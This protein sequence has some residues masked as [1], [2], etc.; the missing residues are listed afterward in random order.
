MPWYIWII[1]VIVAIFF[2]TYINDKQKRERLMKKY[3]DEVLVE[4]L[5]SGS[6]WQG[7]PKGQLIDALGKPEQIS[8]QVLK[9]RKK[10]IWKYQ[11]TG[12]NRYALKITIEDGKVIGWDKK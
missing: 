8:E 4:K 12:T 11:K 7:Q 10:E 3:K 5:M 9:T 6:F 1:L 2:I